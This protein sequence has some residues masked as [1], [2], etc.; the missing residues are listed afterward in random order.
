MTTVAL[1][2]TG[3]IRNIIN[4]TGGPSDGGNNVATLVNYP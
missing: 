4:T 2:G 3:T 1:G